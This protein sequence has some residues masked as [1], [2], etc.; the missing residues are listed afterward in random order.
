MKDKR[1][2]FKI[3][4]GLALTVAIFF[5]EIPGACIQAFKDPIL[6]VAEK[7]NL[8]KQL[9]KNLDFTLDKKNQNLTFLANKNPNIP[10]T[11]PSFK[12]ANPELAARDFLAGYARYFGI[13]NPNQELNLSKKKEDILGMSHVGFRQVF[14]GIPVFG[15]QIIVNTG[16]EGGVNSA[17]GKILPV[18][19]S[20]IQVKISEE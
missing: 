3:K 6:N 9:G 12:R 1:I 18:R 20:D 16:Q 11:K 13:N 8:R 7:E 4:T 10:L 19:I 15:G 14:R 5:L 17:N 2:F